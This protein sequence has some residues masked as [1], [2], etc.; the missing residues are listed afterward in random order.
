MT[1]AAVRATVRAMIEV[2]LNLQ[3]SP[4]RRDEL[5]AM[6]DRLELA[7]AADDAYLLDVEVDVSVDDPEKVLVVS[8]W[9]S[10]EHYERWQH[11]RGWAFVVEPLTPLLAAEPE[12]HAYRLAD[13]IR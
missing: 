2:H 9:P 6:L 1:A 7:A 12:V 11:D 10:L 5:L 8:A 13:S 4:G 3:A